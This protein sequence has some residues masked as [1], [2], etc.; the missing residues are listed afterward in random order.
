MWGKSK[1]AKT[2]LWNN[3]KVVQKNR[4]DDDGVIFHLSDSFMKLKLFALTFRK[5]GMTLKHD[6]I[7]LQR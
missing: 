3:S 6:F 4:D 5:N 7:K 1:R 2:N